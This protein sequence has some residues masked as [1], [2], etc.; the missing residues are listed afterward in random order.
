MMLNLI[1][2]QQTFTS[3][4]SVEIALMMLY[5]GTSGQ[6]KKELTDLFRLPPGSYIPDHILKSKLQLLQSTGE[7]LVA[8]AIVSKPGLQFTEEYIAKMKDVFNAEVGNAGAATI[9]DWVATK[10]KGKIIK[11]L[12]YDPDFSLVNVIYL[13][14]VWTTPFSEAQSYD[15]PFSSPQGNVSVTYMSQMN[16][17]NYFEYESYQSVA[18]PFAG[19]IFCATQIYGSCGTTKS[20]YCEPITKQL[21]PG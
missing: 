13:K 3:P 20:S 6:V 10:T 19:G 21:L 7:L 2:N 17:F 5:Y 18:M 4:L 1:P 11:V 9:N 12:N 16:T 14:A 8:N 15:G